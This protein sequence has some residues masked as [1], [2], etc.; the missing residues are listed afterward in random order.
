MPQ[1][2]PVSSGPKKRMRLRVEGTGWASSPPLRI[3]LTIRNF[4]EIGFAYSG[5]SRIRLPAVRHLPAG[6]RGRHSSPTSSSASCAATCCSPW[7]ARWPAAGRPATTRPQLA[8]FV[9]AGQGLLGVVAALGLDRPGRPDPHRRRGHRPAAPGPPGASATSPPTWAG[10]AYAV[11][12]RFVAAGRW[13]A[14]SSSTCTC[15]SALATYPLFAVSVLLAVRGLLRLPVPGQRRRATGC[16]TSAAS[17]ML[18]TLVSGVLGRPVLPA[19]LPA[20]LAAAARSGS[21][22]RS[23]RCCRR[24]WTCWSSGTRRPASSGLVGVQVVWAVLLLALC[25]LVQRRAERRLVVQ[26]G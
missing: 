11:L 25:R 17:L 3:A 6:H 5:I 4:T 7:P 8:T 26:G 24:R 23:R 18:W 19:P 21:A 1:G 10:P 2:H 16:W 9:W 13:S 14:R 12:T 15:R 22:R 20:G